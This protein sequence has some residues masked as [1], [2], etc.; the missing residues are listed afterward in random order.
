VALRPSQRDT[1]PPADYDDPHHGLGPH[2]HVEM[3]LHEHELALVLRALAAYLNDPVLSVPGDPDRLRDLDTQAR[4]AQFYD[5]L[6]WLNR[7]KP[8]R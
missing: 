7:P 2:E 8:Y 3:G 6:Y 5:R 1:E 4:F